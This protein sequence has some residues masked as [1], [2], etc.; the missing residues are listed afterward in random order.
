MLVS[1]KK[2]RQKFWIDEEPHH[3][4]EVA[5]ALDFVGSPYEKHGLC[6][7][8]GAL[9]RNENRGEKDYTPVEGAGCLTLLG[10]D[11]N[12][13]SLA[14]EQARAYDET[15]CH[16]TGGRSPGEQGEGP[17]M[18]FRTEGQE[19]LALL[20]KEKISSKKWRWALFSV[21][22]HMACVV[23]LYVFVQAAFQG[24]FSFM[25]DNPA[26]ET[27]HRL[28]HPETLPG[29]EGETENSPHAK[30]QKS[31][32]SVKQAPLVHMIDL[33]DVLPGQE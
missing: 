20:P 19:Q 12:E 10:N 2:K 22:M 11:V 1:V 18:V 27:S 16:L 30:P 15:A 28:Q 8:E 31:S 32:E 4:E 17:F 23:L 29:T 14:G 5:V 21:V 24:R 3:E 13:K 7:L 33:D 26:P 6:P 9:E 25:F